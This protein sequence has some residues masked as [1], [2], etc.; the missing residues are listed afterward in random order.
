MASEKLYQNTLIAVI[1]RYSFALRRRYQWRP[2]E[3]WLWKLWTKKHSLSA[4]KVIRWVKNSVYFNTKWV[5]QTRVHKSLIGNLARHTFSFFDRN[6]TAQNKQ[7][8]WMIQRLAY[9]WQKDGRLQK[10]ADNQ[11][12]C[13]LIP[14]SQ[15]SFRYKV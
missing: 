10:F 11:I 1:L 7:D 9:H 2:V 8:E 15:M 13:R 4:D 6:K 14:C 5:C 3:Q 12:L